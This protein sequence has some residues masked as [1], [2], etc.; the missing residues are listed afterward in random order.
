M[1]SL[2]DDNDL[3]LSTVNIINCDGGINHFRV[4][5]GTLSGIISRNIY[6]AV[7]PYHNEGMHNN[8][9]C[10]GMGVQLQGLFMKGPHL[11]NW[12]E[13]LPIYTTRAE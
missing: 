9:I 5:N 6:N 8:N 1:N 11:D 2:V 3:D 7:M 13:G 10:V 12:S 4:P